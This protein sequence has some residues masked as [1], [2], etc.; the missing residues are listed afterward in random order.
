MSLLTSAVSSLERS[1]DA[2]P[3]EWRDATLAATRAE[4]AAE[5]ETDRAY[6]GLAKRMLTLAHQ[7]A[8][9]ADVRGVQRL[10]DDIQSTD[11]TLGRK[12]P[13]AVA[14][15]VD[16]VQAELDSARRLRLEQDRWRLRLSDF[17]RY[18][19]A[20]NAS[21]IRLNGI[22][23]QLEDIRALAG[24]GPDAIAVILRDSSYALNNFSSVTPPDEFRPAHALLLS[25]A[26]LAASAARTRREAA[27]TGDMARAWDASSAA[28]GSLMLTERARSDIRALLRLP[29]LPQ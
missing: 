14:A 27:L 23:Q 24:S 2:L 1:A 9:A 17:R 26:Q 3:A 5:L 8:Q 22:K 4:I 19:S 11:E 28:A 16:S 6:D 21:L 15:L 20:I 12:R 18:T 25:A 29:Q 10:L 7:R 13:D